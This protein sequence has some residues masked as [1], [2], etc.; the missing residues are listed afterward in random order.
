MRD[1][2]LDEG[3]KQRSGSCGSERRDWRHESSWFFDRGT[4]VPF[5]NKTTVNPNTITHQIVCLAVNSV[6]SEGREAGSVR[7]NSRATS[8]LRVRH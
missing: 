6:K 8:S 3:W 5:V 2:G 4:A 1:R 7:G